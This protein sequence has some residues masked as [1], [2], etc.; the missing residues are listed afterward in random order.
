MVSKVSF[1][2]TIAEHGGFFKVMYPHW[3]SSTTGIKPILA[4]G[5]KVK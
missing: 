4:T 3:Q 2:Y 5:K 1:I